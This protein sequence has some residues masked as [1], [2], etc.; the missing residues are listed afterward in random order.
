MS[1]DLP[2]AR[3]CVV[4][5]LIWVAL[6][7][8]AACSGPTSPA[9]PTPLAPVSPTQLAPTLVSI[10][11][12]MPDVSQ[13]LAG[14]SRQLIAVAT[15]ST[16]NAREVS[17][18]VTWRSS[19]TVV[20]TVSATGVLQ[21]L[22]PGV[23][24]IEAVASGGV[25]GTLGLEVGAP[26]PPVARLSIQIDNT[27]N[28]AVAGATPVTFNATASEGYRLTYHWDFGD[29][30]TSTTSEPTVTK[31]LARIQTGPA[32]LTV[33][34]AFGRSAS[35][36]AIPYCSVDLRTDP[37]TY[38]RFYGSHFRW[39]PSLDSFSVL[40]VNYQGLNEVSGVYTRRDADRQYDRIDS[41]YNGTISAS[42]TI[43]LRL[44]DGVRLVGRVL[45]WP[46]SPYGAPALELT[47]RGGPDDGR[48]LLMNYRPQY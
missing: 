3:P 42:L 16:G 17:D 36:A 5:T 7:M 47:V 46:P 18:N 12:S 38:P 39:Q 34:D 10:G 32:K 23:V 28:C 8:A 41:K 14:R 11:V 6:V 1:A 22:T 26:A 2:L 45:A 4:G 24:L 37:D 48:R 21:A 15:D 33:S 25:T 35:S 20:A 44:D 29:D 40:F 27:L 31:T 30:R 19:N 9:A 43:D 13:V